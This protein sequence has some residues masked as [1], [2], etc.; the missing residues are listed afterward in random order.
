MTDSSNFDSYEPKFQLNH[1][2]MKLIKTPKEQ[3]GSMFEWDYDESI[4]K[5]KSLILN[6]RNISIEILEELYLARKLLSSQGVRND[7][8]DE[9]KGWSNYLEEIGLNKSTVN[10]WLRKYDPVEKEILNN[11]NK[12]VD[13]VILPKELEGTVDE[14]LETEHK[15][16]HCGYKW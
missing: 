1:I 11:N 13:S 6:W 2:Q 9:K 8:I 14:R 12:P 15:C 10:R 16:P 5:M 4:N 7:L 3:E